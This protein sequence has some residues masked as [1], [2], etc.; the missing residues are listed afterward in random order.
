MADK[1]FGFKVSDELYEKVKMMIENSG[2]S[3]KEW[4]ERAVALAE[5]Q[6][7]KEG[8]PDYKQDLSE[9]EV[10]TT[11]IYEL[12]AN[13]IQRAHYIKEDALRELAEKLNSRELMISSLQADVKALQ[14][15]LSQ[16]DAE[17]KQVIS[18]KNELNK[19][20]EEQRGVNVNN[21]ALIQEYKDK[22]DTLS[23]LVNQYKDYATENTALKEEIAN[24]KERF[25]AEKDTLLAEFEQK[26]SH[27]KS[28]IE[29]LKS[30][31]RDQEDQIEK[32][33]RE[34]EEQKVNHV[35][36]LNRLTE[37]KDLAKERATLEIERKYQE[38]LQEI[39]EQYNEK[40]ARLYE[41]FELKARNNAPQPQRQNNKK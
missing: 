31:V 33:T 1:T 35:N 28:S 12:V 36:E 23:S 29:E 14:D 17:A 37:A 15:R 41:K 20:L 3:S 22:I 10:H 11:R 16:L 9:L 34:N 19:Q 2:S 40:I 4:F 24:L 39:H 8:S 27:L 7:L 6:D 25:T 38:K 5:V 18:E 13:M 32:L 21:Q 30:T 26:E